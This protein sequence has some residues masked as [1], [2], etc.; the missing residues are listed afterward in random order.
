MSDSTGIKVT[1]RRE[2]CLLINGSEWYPTVNVA[3]DIEKKKIRSLDVTSEEVHDDTI[4]NKLV[5][6]TSGNKMSKEIFQ[7]YVS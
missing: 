6:N 5:D 7:I 2:C 1:N 3:V 4:L